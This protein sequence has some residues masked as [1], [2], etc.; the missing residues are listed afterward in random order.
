MEFVRPYLSRVLGEKG[1]TIG[2]V[3]QE[4]LS[5]LLRINRLPRPGQGTWQKLRELL[6]SGRLV[7]LLIALPMLYAWQRQPSVVAIPLWARSKLL[8]I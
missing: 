4:L 1:Y 5:R 8:C 2:E 7:E 6:L 3:A